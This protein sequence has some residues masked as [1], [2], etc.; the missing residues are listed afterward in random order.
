MDSSL[1]FFLRLSYKIEVEGW[2]RDVE[3]EDDESRAAIKQTAVAQRRLGI[4]ENFK[5]E[6]GLIID[7]PKSGVGNSN[8]GNVARSFFRHSLRRARQ[9][10]E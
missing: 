6:L 2:L 3:D 10:P 1:E 4:Q 7:R 9:S 8:S 5:Q